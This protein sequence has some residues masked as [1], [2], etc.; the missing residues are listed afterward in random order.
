MAVDFVIAMYQ[1]QKLAIKTQNS[2]YIIYHTMFSM[3]HS[4]FIAAFQNTCFA[5]KLNI[6]QVTEQ[7]LCYDI[8]TI[9]FKSS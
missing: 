9:S 3:E 8:T 6:T 7:N 4:Q 2:S 5:T 1:I